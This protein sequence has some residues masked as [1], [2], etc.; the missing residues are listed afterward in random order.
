M[1]HQNDETKLQAS[2]ENYGSCSSISIYF[3]IQMI[4]R[5]ELKISNDTEYSDECVTA[6]E[7]YNCGLT[8][9][10]VLTVSLVKAKT[11]NTTVVR[12]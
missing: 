6:D 12:T 10:P 11:E 7:I 1:F 8:K 4:E 5:Q 3:V 9:E 2:Y